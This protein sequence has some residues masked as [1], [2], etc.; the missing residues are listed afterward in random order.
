MSK[1]R[2][3]RVEQKP[4]PVPVPSTAHEPAAPAAA[5]AEAAPVPTPEPVAPPPELTRRDFLASAGTWVVAA[6]GAGAVAGAVRFSLP[7]TT[8][9]A[10]QRFALGTPADFKARTV[11]WLRDH[12]L[13][14]V[15]DEKGFGAFSSKCTHLGCTVQRTAEGFAC[16]CHGA[17]YDALGRVLAGPARRALPWFALWQEFDGRIWI[18]LTRSAEAGCAPLAAPGKGDGA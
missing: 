5:A 9:G 16:P 17:K 7:E 15:R 8:E 2:K 14:V 6:C 10:A 12:Q 3:G 18:D 11:T 4:V 13:F 1:K